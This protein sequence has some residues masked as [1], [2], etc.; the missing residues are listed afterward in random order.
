[1][2]ILGT[3]DPML[4]FDAL[5]VFITQAT[6]AFD[7]LDE[8]LVAVTAGGRA[9]TAFSNSR[10]FD[11]L[12][13]PGRAKN[14]ARAAARVSSKGQTC[15]RCQE[16]AYSFRDHRCSAAVYGPKPEAAYYGP[17]TEEPA[18]KKRRIQKG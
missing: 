10:K 11:M 9:A 16:T 15:N 5:G 17:K 8:R 4:V 7:A 12:N 6:E 13:L 1:M 3:V 2:G 14:A 18:K